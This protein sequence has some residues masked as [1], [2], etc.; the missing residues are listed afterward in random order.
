MSSLDET[1]TSTPLTDFFFT[2]S[3]VGTPPSLRLGSHLGLRTGDDTGSHYRPGTSGVK[4]VELPPR[5]TYPLDS[6]CRTG[7]HCSQRSLVVVRDLGSR[8]KVEKGSDRH[9]GTSPI[10]EGILGGDLLV[11]FWTD[12][13]LHCTVLRRTPQLYVC[14]DDRTPSLSRTTG[15]GTLQR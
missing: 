15:L 9:H 10:Y 7:S 5:L 1:T 14:K 3:G 2:L 12:D 11:L 4:S 13:V 6:P 8:T